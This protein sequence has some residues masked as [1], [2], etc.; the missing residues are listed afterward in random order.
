MGCVRFSA[1]A[2][3]GFLVAFMS[4]CVLSDFSAFVDVCSIVSFWKS[5]RT[6]PMTLSQ[7]MQMRHKLITFSVLMYHCFVQILKHVHK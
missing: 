1:C 3:P 6:S 4:I 2:F 7:M 5:A